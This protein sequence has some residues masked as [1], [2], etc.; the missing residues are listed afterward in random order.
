MLLL[1]N[2]PCDYPTFWRFWRIKFTFSYFELK[3]IVGQFLVNSLHFIT[4]F[5]HRR[6]S[7]DRQQPIKEWSLK[8]NPFLFAQCIFT[9]SENRDSDISFV[10]VYWRY[11]RVS[12][13]FSHSK[14]TCNDSEQITLI[15]FSDRRT[16]INVVSFAIIIY[17]CRFLTNRGESAL[18]DGTKERLGRRLQYARHQCILFLLASIRATEKIDNKT[19]VYFR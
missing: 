16:A 7:P 10:R 11:N 9:Y 8:H 15:F 17:C 5:T 4:Y 3:P 6:Q 2:F 1:V 19:P 13:C 14:S 12:V 18:C